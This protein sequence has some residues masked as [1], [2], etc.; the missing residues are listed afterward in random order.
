MRLS[1]VL[2]PLLYTSGDRF[3]HDLAVGIAPLAGLEPARRLTAQDAGADATRFQAAALVR[4][5]NRV[6]D[7]LDRATEL[8]DELSHAADRR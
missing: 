7:A 3:E 1:R 5:R 2:V 4:E 6:L 8:A